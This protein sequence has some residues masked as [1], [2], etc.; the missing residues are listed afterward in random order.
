MPSRGFSRATSAKRC[1]SLGL[2]SKG[3]SARPDGASEL[4]A[5]RRL[6]N[7]PGFCFSRRCRAAA[8]AAPGRDDP[9]TG[10]ADQG[11][12]IDD[13]RVTRADQGTT[14]DGERVTR[15][16]QR[17]TIARERAT[18]ADQGTTIDR[19]RTARDHQRTTIDDERVSRDRE[20]AGRDNQRTSL[21]RELQNVAFWGVSLCTQMVRRLRKR[22]ADPKA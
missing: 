20:R 2:P 14:V 6:V 5:R 7:E 10:C 9:Q 17:A 1:T 4:A 3:R 18:R 13:E 19:E 21:D 8:S 15:D 16:D 11:T 12:T 22:S